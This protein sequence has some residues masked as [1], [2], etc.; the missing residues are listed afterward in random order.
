M[1]FEKDVADIAI[2]VLE[3]S[4]SGVVALADEDFRRGNYTNSDFDILLNGLLD[5]ADQIGL[6]DVRSERQLVK[7][8]SRLVPLLCA[9]YLLETGRDDEL[10]SR[11]VREFERL[12]DTYE[13]LQDKLEDQDSRGRGRRGR[14]RDDDRRRGRRRSRYDDEDFD[15]GDAF[16]PGRRRDSRRRDDDRFTRRR[17]RKGRDNGRD[18][19]GDGQTS[20]MEARLAR[21]E[22]RN[23]REEEP[24]GTVTRGYNPSRDRNA[25]RSSVVVP[26]S[27]REINEEER[28][29]PRQERSRSYALVGQGDDVKEEKVEGNFST[30]EDFDISSWAE[31]PQGTLQD[32]VDLGINVKDQDFI[33]SRELSPVQD[34]RE[35]IYD[36][37]TVVPRWELDETGGRTLTFKTMEM[38]IDNHII[39]DFSRYSSGPVASQRPEVLNSVVQ[40]SRM[41]ILDV[42]NVQEENRKKRAEEIAKWEATEEAERGEQPVEEIDLIP[43]G[44]KPL[45]VDGFVNADSLGQMLIKSQGEFAKIRGVTTGESVVESCGAIVNLAH[46]SQSEVDRDMLMTQINMFTTNFEHR[47]ESST[48]GRTAVPLEEYHENMMALADKIPLGLWKRINRNMTKYVN[49]ILTISL[50][51]SLTI[52]DFA[53]DG[54][55]VLTH[56]IDTRGKTVATNFM[57]GHVQNAGRLAF[58]TT[59]VSDDIANKELQ[60][61]GIFESRNTA[62]TMFPCSADELNI[63]AVTTSETNKGSFLVT[64]T[65]N[66]RLH[67]ALRTIRSQS[68]P[69]VGRAVNYYYITFSDGSVYRVDSNAVAERNTPKYVLT[70]V[71]FY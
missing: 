26:K 2:D 58:F 37:Y 65:N 66:R 27:P 67:Q 20:A 8:I 64:E 52:D 25:A 49:D 22:Q 31:V 56:L 9:Q 39:P 55:K 34:M 28:R 57:V 21:R 48:G 62:V 54:P 38:D 5:L 60:S 41:S 45:R 14:G 53:E 11:D 68:A 3:D 18:G 16:R 6:D 19:S 63:S 40:P 47:P 43:V 29:T 1:S 4:R 46:M 70:L 23:D 69:I 33:M 7:T 12:L 59:K 36:P 13:D 44:R 50:G 42:A 15:D 10:D 32:Y 61:L 17:G 71:G 35:I 24:R 30:L 51:L